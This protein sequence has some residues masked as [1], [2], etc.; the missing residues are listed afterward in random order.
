MR[1]SSSGGHRLPAGVFPARTGH[2]HQFVGPEKRVVQPLPAGEAL[3]QP[4]V[5]GVFAQR[6]LDL[7]AVT[8]RHRDPHPGE[9]R[10]E[11]RQDRRQQ[12]LRNGRAGPETKFAPG[13]VGAEAHLVF[14]AAVIVEEPFGGLQHRTPRIGQLQ[15]AAAAG[16][17][18]HLITGFQLADVLADGG[19]RNVELFGGPGETQR[20]SRGDKDLEA[21]IVHDGQPRWPSS[22]NSFTERT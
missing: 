22:A 6:L 14:E 8:R 15:T 18:L 9:A 7:G 3:D 16:E 10:R 13:L 4:Q 20:P 2:Q 19:L 11:V 5:H 21:E 17:K 12:I 1:E